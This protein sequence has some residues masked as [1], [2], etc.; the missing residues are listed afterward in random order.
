MYRL[1]SENLIQT[2]PYLKLEGTAIGIQD[3]ISDNLVMYID[4]GTSEGTETPVT[5]ESPTKFASV[6]YSGAGP[7]RTVAYAVMALPNAIEG[8]SFTPSLLKCTC[9][10]Y[11]NADRTVYYTYLNGKYY[12]HLVPDDKTLV[13]QVN[14]TLIMAVG[15]NKEA[16]DVALGLKTSLLASGQLL[17]SPVN[18]SAIG[19][20]KCTT[21]TNTNGVYEFG[22]IFTLYKISG[23]KSSSQ[24][25]TNMSA[26]AAQFDTNQVSDYPS[27]TIPE[28]PNATGV[29]LYDSNS[30]KVNQLLKQIAGLVSNLNSLYVSR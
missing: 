2:R 8:R 18:S 5:L 25:Y 29:Y 12:A 7:V 4:T 17:H 28:F 20:I 26:S 16:A 15:V 23:T 30:D 21:P 10:I 27:I 24:A 9:K 22:T 11:P 3:A 1:L 6:P 13:L 14:E 19:T